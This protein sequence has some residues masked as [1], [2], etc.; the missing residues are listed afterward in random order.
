MIHPVAF[1]DIIV[2]LAALAAMAGLARRANDYF[3]ISTRVLLACLSFFLL[4]YGICLAVEW[5]GISSRFDRIEDYFGALLPMSWAFV[6]YSFLNEL[7]FR[8]IQDLNTQL[9][10]RVDLLKEAELRFRTIFDSASDGI[11][12]ADVREKTFFAANKKLC[13]MLGYTKEELQKL[14]LPDIHPEASLALVNEQFDKLSA[15]E[16]SVAQNIPLLKKDQDVF[17]SDVSASLMTF[18]K[19]NFLSAFSEISPNEGKR[20]KS[21][22]NPKKNFLPFSISTPTLWPLP[23]S[24]PEPLSISIKPSSTGRDT[25]VKK[26]SVF[27]LTTF[28]YGSI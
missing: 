8:N 12:I 23:M 16:I 20:R 3:L 10:Q 17:F 7:S 1:L 9:K 26:S 19:K 6:F 2:I 28:I 13:D 24:T 21:S 5:S 4:L 25:P 11:L 27:P 18:D 14:G 15:G 22:S